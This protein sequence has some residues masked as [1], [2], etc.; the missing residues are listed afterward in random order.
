M[1]RVWL[2]QYNKRVAEKEQEHTSF[3]ATTKLGWE[4]LCALFFLDIKV[5]A[6]S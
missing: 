3:F 5:Q 6:K 4:T 2:G 1:N